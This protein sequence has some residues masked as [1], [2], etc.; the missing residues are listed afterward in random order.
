MKEQILDA[1]YRLL[2][3]NYDRNNL[4]LLINPKAWHDIFMEC[5]MSRDTNM[6]NSKTHFHGVEVIRSYYVPEDNFYVT[7][8]NP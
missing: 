1:I 6:F 7:T 2:Q 5:H 8:K 4:F 3:M